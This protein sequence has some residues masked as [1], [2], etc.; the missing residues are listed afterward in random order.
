[1]SPQ[2]Y[3]VIFRGLIVSLIRPLDRRIK[4]LGCSDLGARYFLA[5]VLTADSTV[6]PSLSRA[7]IV[8]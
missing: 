6:H 5:G 3:G 4:T 2:K 7:N 1:M 8:V